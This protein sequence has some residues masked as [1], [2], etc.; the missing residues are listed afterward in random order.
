M[1]ANNSGGP[2]AIGFSIPTFYNAMLRAISPR[3]LLCANNATRLPTGLWSLA[4]SPGPASAKASN[5]SRASSI[6]TVASIFPR[7]MNSPEG[8]RAGI[9]PLSARRSKSSRSTAASSSARSTSVAASSRHCSR[10]SSPVTPTGNNSVSKVR[11]SPAASNP[12][13]R[14]FPRRNAAASLRSSPSCARSSRNSAASAIGAFG[15]DFLFQFEPIQ[16]R[17]PRHGHRDLHLYLCDDIYFMDRKKEQIERCQYDFSQDALSTNGL[18][19]DAAE[20]APAPALPPAPIFS[21]HTPEEYMANVETVREGMR[22][23]D[24]Y[25][26]VLCQTFRSEERRVGKECRS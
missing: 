6:I 3:D 16:K 9:S 17:L 21:D 15:Y 10:R 13:R 19:R 24:Y 4:P 7:D 25:E 23:G 20:I 1:R 18:P 5:I 8:I 26:V 12:C 22:C 14:S 11:R 2:L